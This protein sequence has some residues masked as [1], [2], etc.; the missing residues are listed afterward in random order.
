MDEMISPMCLALAKSTAA[1]VPLALAL[2]V[3][4]A[5][6]AGVETGGPEDF[7]LTSWVSALEALSSV[8]GHI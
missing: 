4:V 8:Y 2:A 5:P 1:D 6:L 3:A 7:A